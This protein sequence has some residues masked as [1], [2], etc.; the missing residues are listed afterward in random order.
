MTNVS[1]VHPPREA[2]VLRAVVLDVVQMRARVLDGSRAG[3][4]GV[5][6]QCACLP[7]RVDKYSDE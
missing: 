3:E 2:L 5:S 1:S 6:N 7:G 4:Q